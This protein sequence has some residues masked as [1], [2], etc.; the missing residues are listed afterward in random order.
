ML[1]HKEEHILLEQ[2]VINLWH[3]DYQIDKEYWRNVF[4]K[5]IQMG[6]WH[7][8]VPKRKELYWYQLFIDDKS[9][10]KH[11][12]KSVEKDLNIYGM[13]NFPRFSYQFP[14][15]ILPHH[16]D[17]DNGVAINLNLLDTPVTIHLENKP[18]PYEAA[19]INV[20]GVLHGV[21]KDSNARL[22]LKFFLRH[23]L[24][25]VYNNLDKIGIIK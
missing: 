19:F 24:E 20:G 14:N 13:N 12:T 15:T 10:L 22:I 6:K 3:L 23:D 18:Y 21:E 1:V 7:H 25:E 4:Y 5:N 17:E 11:L 2:S 8:S 9:P 16:K